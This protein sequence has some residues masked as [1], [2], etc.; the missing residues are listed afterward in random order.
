MRSAS[1]LP[2]LTPALEISVHR[3][4]LSELASIWEPLVDPHHPGAGF[5][6]WAWISAWWNSFSAGV[7][8]SVFR[9]LVVRAAI[10]WGKRRAVS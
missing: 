7:R 6:S 9:F 10:K 1:S 2:K 5:R 8:S 3:G 4:D